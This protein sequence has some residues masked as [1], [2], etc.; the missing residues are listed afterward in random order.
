VVVAAVAVVAVAAVAV[1]AVA[2]AVVVV[3]IAVAV[4]VVVTIVV[5]VVS[6]KRFPFFWDVISRHRVVCCR[7]FGALLWPHLQD[8][9]RPRRKTRVV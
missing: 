4:F 9:Q 5:L 6:H 8:S 7:C 3:A 2:V 1:V